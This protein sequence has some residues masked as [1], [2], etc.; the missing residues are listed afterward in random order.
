MAGRRSAGVAVAVVFVI[1]SFPSE[2]TATELPR[3]SGEQ[4]EGL[5][6]GVT[7]GWG[8]VASYP[9]ITGRVDVDAMIHSIA[10]R[11]GYVPRP[12]FEGPLVRV[13]GSLLAAEAAS[14][15]V[16]LRS[17]AAADGVSLRIVSGFRDFDRQRQMFA[18]SLSGYSAAA[19]DARLRWAAPPGFS[20]HHTGLAVDLADPSTSGRFANSAGHAW[21][22]DNGYRNAMRFG[23]IP[24]YPP[25]G[26]PVGPDPEPW[27]WVYV[28]L[29]VIRCGVGSVRPAPVP[30]W[31]GSESHLSRSVG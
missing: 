27:E 1:S 12:T 9:E 22:A 23:F 8:V 3:Y 2:A 24:S 19:V 25:D 10:T 11:R 17:A 15:W 20:K 5:F 21:L 28:G 6:L 4:F 7:S 13:D 30:V 31:C 18:G 14:A 26:P 29:E 16:R